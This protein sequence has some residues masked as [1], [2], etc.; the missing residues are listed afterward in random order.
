M[1][2]MYRQLAEAGG[3]AYEMEYQMKL[4]SGGGGGGNP[5]GGLLARMATVTMHTT[6]TEVA[7]G[8]LSDDMFAPPA[9]YKANQKK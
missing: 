8:A 1:T 7:T 5:L 9:G 6:V 3:I 2:E 4:G